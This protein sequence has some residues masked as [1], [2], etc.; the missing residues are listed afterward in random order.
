MIPIINFPEGTKITLNKSS[1]T[2]QFDKNDPLLEGCKYAYF[3]SQIYSARDIN[4]DYYRCFEDSKCFHRIKNTTPNTM[5]RCFAQGRCNYDIILDK[6][7]P[8]NFEY[9]FF[10]GYVKNFLSVSGRASTINNAFASTSIKYLHFDIDTS[11]VSTVSSVFSTS[12]IALYGKFSIKNCSYFYNYSLT[13]FSNAKVRQITI[14]DIGYKQTSLSF[15][16]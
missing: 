13:G 5:Y 10:N 2:D 3:A 16:Y 11:G 6:N 8:I 7:T 9:T 1:Y 14:A 12:L 15:T 4:M